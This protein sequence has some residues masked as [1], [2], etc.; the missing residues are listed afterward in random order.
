MKIALMLVVVTISF[1][2]VTAYPSESSIFPRQSSKL[3]LKAHSSLTTIFTDE[4]QAVRHFASHGTATVTPAIN[5]VLLGFA[6]KS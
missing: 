1:G 5:I 2:F 4:Y 6:Y 3:I